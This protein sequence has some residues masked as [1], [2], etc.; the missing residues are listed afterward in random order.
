M[1]SVRG[2]RAQARPF[3]YFDAFIK[4]FSDSYDAVANENGYINVAVAQNNLTVD[5]MHERTCRALAVESPVNTAAYDDMKG[6]MRL[7]S[8]MAAHMTKRLCAGNTNVSAGD[9]VLSAGAGA[10]IENLVF[11]I[12]D[13]GEQVIIPA[14][15][16]PAFPNDLR[17][18][19]GV[20]TVPC[21]SAVAGPDG[22]TLPTAQDYA[23][24]LD[25]QHKKGN[26]KCVAIL[27][28][29]P[30]NPTGVVYSAEQL[31]ETIAW[32]VENKIHV[33]SDEIYACSIFAETCEHAFVSAISIV[34]EMIAEAKDDGKLAIA[35]DYSNYVHVIYGMSKDFCTS[36]YRVGTLWTQNQAI[37]RALDNVSYFCAIPGPFQHALSLVLEDEK[38]LHAFFVENQK[39]LR[40]QFDIVLEEFRGFPSSKDSAQPY[41]PS[42]IPSAGMFV[43]FSLSHLLPPNPTFEQEQA[44]WQHVYDAA[45]VVLTPGADCASR[46]PGWFRMCF[47][48]VS[49]DT[50][51]VAIRRVVNACK[52]FDISREQ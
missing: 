45:K 11:S 33:I 28:A 14:P 50:L 3:S 42:I 1:V 21:Y 31:K 23:E 43:Y 26:G 12:S 44:L 39:R 34:S 25:A 36:G 20:S 22:S 13:E 52:S 41:T 18:R 9:L 32:A 51:R 47:A 17:A 35:A 49:P 46:H 40:R 30:G 19:L 38:F 7:K 16:Y 37:H 4:T 48:A 8:A 24:L 27:L 2:T 5:M 10:V 29:N 6:T 15:Y